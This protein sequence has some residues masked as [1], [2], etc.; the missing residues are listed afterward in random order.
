LRSRISLLLLS[1]SQIKLLQTAH[2][3]GSHTNNVSFCYLAP[4][5]GKEEAAG[6]LLLQM[7]ITLP[8]AL[9]AP[10]LLAST[11]KPW[12]FILTQLTSLLVALLLSLDN[13][14]K[15]KGEK[16]KYAHSPK[17][18]ITFST[19]SHPGSRPLL[20]TRTAQSSSGGQTQ[21]CFLLYAQIHTSPI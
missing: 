3:Q 8:R 17:T 2:L 20:T 13:K 10:Q 12:P 5:L 7:P 19:I 15:W 11:S 9:Q 6:H 18:G 4:F 1:S 21:S 14:K 16:G